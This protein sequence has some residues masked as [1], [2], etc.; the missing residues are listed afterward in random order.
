MI[1]GLVFVHVKEFVD[2]FQY[3]DYSV[4]QGISYLITEERRRMEFAE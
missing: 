2:F 4:C 3:N 1:S